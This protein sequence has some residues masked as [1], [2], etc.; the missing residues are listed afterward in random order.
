MWWGKDGVDQDNGHGGGAYALNAT[1]ICHAFAPWQRAVA[2]AV[3]RT[4]SDSGP[5]GIRLD[6]CAPL[7]LGRETSFAQRSNTERLLSTASATFTTSSAGTPITTMRIRSQTT[8]SKLTSP[9]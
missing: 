8:V 4:I 6:G 2:D 7:G 5:D 1:Y 3:G 9:S